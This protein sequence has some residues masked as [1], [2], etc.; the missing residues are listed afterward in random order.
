MMCLKQVA[1]GPNSYPK[2]SVIFATL[3]SSMIHFDII[4]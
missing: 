2:D 4:H 1:T 3:Y